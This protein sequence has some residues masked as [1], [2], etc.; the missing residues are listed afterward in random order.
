MQKRLLR[1]EPLYQ[2]IDDKIMRWGCCPV[3]FE[4]KFPQNHP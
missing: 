1:K 3:G 4:D 2:R